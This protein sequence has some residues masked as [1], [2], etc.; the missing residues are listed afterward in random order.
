M[1]IGLINKTNSYRMAS[2]TKRGKPYRK[3]NG[4]YLSEKRNNI[5]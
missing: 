3:G 5:R 1:I 4:F 2:F